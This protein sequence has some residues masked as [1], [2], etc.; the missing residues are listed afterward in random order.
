MSRSEGGGNIWSKLLTSLRGGAQDLGDGWVDSRALRILDQEIRDCDLDLRQSRESLAHLLARHT[1]AE[2][3]LSELGDKVGEYEGYAIKAME[4]GDE[5]LAREVADK[6]VQLESNRSD[7]QRHV[8]E[9]AASAAELRKSVAMAEGNI[10]R[11]KQQLD[12]VKATQSVQRAQAAVAQRYAGPH[13]KLQTAI[14]SLARI[15]Q[16]QAE[17]GARMEAA[18]ELA[19][20][21][22]GDAL[23]RKLRDAGIMP[24][25]AGAEAVLLRL[26]QKMPD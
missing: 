1:L 17:R 13:N 14:D 26:R 6:I 16:K 11:L 7:D 2:R 8:Q 22:R 4:S 15:K 3:A 9:L 12:T 5:A 18:A 24:D 10:R 21:D 20:G 23:E 19:R 25:D